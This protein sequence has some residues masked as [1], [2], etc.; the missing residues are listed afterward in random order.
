[1]ITKCTENQ[2]KNIY[3]VG[4]GLGEG[5]N[6]NANEKLNMVAGNQGMEES[7]EEENDSFEEMNEAEMFSFMAEVKEES[8]SD[9]ELS[10]ESLSIEELYKGDYFD[11]YADEEYEEGSAR[12]EYEEDSE[13]EDAEEEE[14]E[15]NTPQVEDCMQAYLKQIG[16]IELL[17]Q[18]EEQRLGKIIKEGGEGALEARNKLVEANLRLVVHCAK[19]YLGRGVAM[20][21]LNLMGTEGLIRAAEKFDYEMGYKF[22]TYAIW[23]IKQSIARGIADEGSSVRVPVHMNDNIYKVKKAKKLFLQQN[24]YEPTVEEIVELTGL[25]IEKV[26]AAIDSMYSIVSMDTK[27]GDDGDS[28]ME[29][30]LA[31]ENA[32]SPEL[33]AMRQGLKEAVQEVL[34]QLLPKEAL[35]LS[36]RFGINTERPMTLEE[37]ANLPGFHVTRE[38]VRQIET[39]ALRKI[40]RS[41]VMKDRLRD[42]AS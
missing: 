39:K 34:G 21:D 1:M 13:A 32:P 2:K 31:D 19:K 8:I 16:Q 20:E 14:Y 11:A 37:I 35:V 4:E 12:D 29:N 42:F 30:F 26:M 28:T 41:S 3:F 9:D 33:M 18:E 10:D 23:W 25:T 22:S 24:G 5:M 15:D 36:L 6:Q 38:R 27:V 40:K 7:F 17:S